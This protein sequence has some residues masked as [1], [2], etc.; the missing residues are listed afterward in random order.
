MHKQPCQHMQGAHTRTHPHA[1]ARQLETRL[2]AQPA[3]E[4]QVRC[5]ADASQDVVDNKACLTACWRQDQA[6]GGKA[7][8]AQTQH[9]TVNDGIWKGREPKPKWCQIILSN[10]GHKEV[11]GPALGSSG[12]MG[13][14]RRKRQGQENCQ[15]RDPGSN[16]GPSDLQSDALPTELSG[17]CALNIT[18]PTANCQS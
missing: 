9:N 8:D 2:Q 1:Q 10:K 4:C 15:C 6:G 14:E 18:R 5:Q 11:H 16:W 17:L 13:T 12:W 3:Q 7:A